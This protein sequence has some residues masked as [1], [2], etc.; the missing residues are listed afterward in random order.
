MVDLILLRHGRTDWNAARRIQ[1]QSDSQL[2]PLGHAQAEAV[3]PV[4]A[5]LAP[6]V[7]WA[8]DSD[9]ARDTASYV[10]A[11]CGL[12][13]RFDQRLREYSLG[14][15]EGLYH[16]EFEAEAPE[17]YAE[18]VRANWDA[19]DGAEK[20]SEVAARMTDAL[21]EAAAAVPADGTALVVSHGA[22]IRTAVAAMLGWPSE[23]ALTVHGMDNCGWAVLRRRTPDARW[24]LHAYN[25]TVPIR[26]L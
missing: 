9:R 14:H 8:S 2:D 20:Q 4:L 26:S 15:R 11:A 13:P 12:T 16:H 21:A 7:L 3:A 6:D 10:A 19:V 18:F 22:A 25:R 1:G 23:D 24:R 5:A 17:E